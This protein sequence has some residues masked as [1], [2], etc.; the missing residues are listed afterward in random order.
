MSTTYV[1]INARNS[2]LE[3]DTNNIFEYQLPEA[4][5]LPA[6]T[7]ISVQ[8]ALIN[9]QGITGASIEID[10]E[11]NETICFQYYVSDSTYQAPRGVAG[12]VSTEY[13]LYDNIDLHV[14][15]DKEFGVPNYGNQG[16]IGAEPEFDMGW[17]ENIMPLTVSTK[18]D[19]GKLT[20]Y[21]MCGI[22][23]I[24]I[25]KGVYSI[26]KLVTLISD[27]INQ[28]ISI[29]NERISNIQVDKLNSEY[30]GLLVNN[31]MNRFVKVEGFKSGLAT[32]APEKNWVEYHNAAP[33][34]VN[35]TW[36][37]FNSQPG[38]VIPMRRAMRVTDLDIP[39]VVA[40]TCQQNELIR[41]AVV[42]QK[43][44]ESA[45]QD[46]LWTNFVPAHKPAGFKNP[47]GKYN[48]VFQKPI[49]SAKLN[50]DLAENRLLYDIFKQGMGV[51]TT[52]FNI[53]Y[54]SVRSAFSI[55]KCHET[56]REPTHDRYG[57]TLPS[58]G[59][60]VSYVKIP[61]QQA[62]GD[63]GEVD[64]SGAL[65]MTPEQLSTIKTLVQRYSGVCIYNWAYK[66]CLEK[67]NTYIDPQNQ[68]GL[69][70]FQTYDEFFNN[71]ADATTAWDDTIWRRMGFTYADLQSKNAF[72]EQKFFGNDIETSPGFTT[73]NQIGSS[74]IPYISTLYNPLSEA[75]TKQ[76]AP[77]GGSIAL[78]S[79]TGLH[80]FN[81]LN[82]SV[83]VFRFTNN[84]KSTTPVTVAQYQASFYSAAVMFPIETKELDVT[85]TELPVLTE[86]GYLYILSN[87]VDQNDIVK[88]KDNVGLLDQLPKSNLSNQDFISDRTQINHTIANEKI[89]NSIRIQ[90]LNPDLTNVSLQKNSSILIK[91]TKPMEK[92]TV[93]L[94]KI[95]N[96]MEENAVQQN[97]QAEIAQ[98]QKAQAQQAKPKRKKK[99]T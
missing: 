61:C 66:T 69:A 88:F 8:N 87:L 25:E 2:I 35:G 84:I 16:A 55:Q 58:P 91:I 40:V 90:I 79:V 74:A 39:T 54:D 86:N 11:Y 38:T 29:Q 22:V 70:E 14:N 15:Q 67:G 46:L 23:D 48:M 27:Q 5:S 1:D 9:L 56:R 44:D 42:E 92:S 10:Q 99:A 49:G 65:P 45:D 20:T 82:Y 3:N 93:L 64:G 4:V 85:A 80:S 72:T 83:P 28:R 13:K 63:A 31:T 36:W 89:L 43:I 26:S 59:A 78:P 41:R 6:G 34:Y 30:T 96:T 12:G 37:T 33:D 98:A 94:N 95:K 57:N 60:G 17:S 51:G 75:G 62:Q 76:A 50:S 19:N 77:A 7:N 97:V 53:N 21:P 32:D 71:E 18:D 24:K 47:D 52:G 81:L 73:R 68:P